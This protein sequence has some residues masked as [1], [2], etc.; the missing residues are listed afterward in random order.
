MWI[1]APRPLKP[2]VV[3][4]NF[5]GEMERREWPQSITTYAYIT[6]DIYAY[7]CQAK[8]KYHL[9]ALVPT[10]VV[11]DKVSHLIVFER[12]LD[13]CIR[14]TYRSHLIIFFV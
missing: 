3:D 14:K 5:T 10:I 6:E 12:C 13:D 11:F 1:I 2:Y 4:A 8:P 9:F 7:V